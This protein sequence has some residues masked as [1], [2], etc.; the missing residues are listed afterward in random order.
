M[1]S[2]GLTGGQGRVWQ[3]SYL[4]RS[5][6]LIGPFSF[7]FICAAIILTVRCAMPQFVR[8]LVILVNVLGLAFACVAI[9]WSYIFI[10]E[11]GLS[12]GVM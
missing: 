4:A 2:G 5:I 7:I 3:G 10:K 1:V 12:L 11:N 8:R 6:L 9:Y